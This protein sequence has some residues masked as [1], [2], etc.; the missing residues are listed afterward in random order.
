MSLFHSNAPRLPFLI[1]TN[2]AL[3][4][5]V[6]SYLDELL[7]DEEKARVK[8]S[9]IHRYFPQSVDVLGDLNTAFKLWD[10]VYEGVKSSGGAMKE[11]DR[12]YWGEANDWLSSKR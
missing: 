1:S 8:D 11:A 3:S 9:T 4:I 5:A 10:A 7:N 2:C 6:K 12:K